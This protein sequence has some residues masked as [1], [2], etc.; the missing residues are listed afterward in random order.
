MSQ[1]GL[2]FYDASAGD[3]AIL[4]SKGLTTNS[5]GNAERPVQFRFAVHA[6][7]AIRAWL[8]LDHRAAFNLSN[9]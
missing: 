8:S 3:P 4:F 6:D 1:G 5:T 7:I 2:I 9:L